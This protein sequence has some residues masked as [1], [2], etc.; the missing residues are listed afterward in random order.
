MKY[1]Y[2][3]ITK[4]DNEIKIKKGLNRDIVKQ[5]SNLKKEDKWMLNFRTKAFEK[6]LKLKNPSWGPKLNKINFNEYYYYTSPENKWGEVPTN[7]KE[8]FK[9]LG[10]PEAEAKILSGV[11][12]QFDSKHVFNELEKELEKKGVIFCGLDEAY[13]KHPSLIKKYLGT[14]VSSVDNKF[15]AL[16]S[17]VWSGGSF[18]FVPKNV[19]IDK[20]LQAY[21]RIN[22]KSSGQFERTLIILEENSEAHYMEG[23]TAPIYSKNNLH[24]A[25]VEVFVGK[26]SKF[27]Y[28]TIQNWSNNVLNLVTKR[29]LVEENGYMEWIDGNIGSG[30]NMKYPSTILKGNNS[31]AKCISIATSGT[32]MV[33]DTGAKMIHIGKNTRSNIISKSIAKNG[34]VSNYRGLVKITKSATNSYSEVNCDSLILDN[35]SKTD[36]YPT[37]IISNNT[38]FI[39]HEAKITDFDKEVK[40]FLNSKGLSQKDA[41]QMLVLGFIKPFSDELPLEYAVELNRLIKQVI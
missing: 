5:I 3:F 28:S 4:T 34:G 37:E 30:L 11:N 21:F 16:N 40:F 39:K 17:S 41:E 25:V 32:G 31:S 33:Q 29:A 12:E 7:I 20:P 24:A 10:V 23:C 14:L 18:L 2:G 19:K 13:A 36:T 26:N 38:S 27:K 22:T 35:L 15:A 1:K 8:A 6:F 9:K